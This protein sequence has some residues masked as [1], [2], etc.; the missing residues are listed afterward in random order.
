M[1]GLV[2]AVGFWLFGYG[3]WCFRCFAGLFSVV[4]RLGFQ[5]SGLVVAGVLVWLLV[6]CG[7]GLGWCCC[8]LLWF[9]WRGVVLV[10]GVRLVGMVLVVAKCCGFLLFARSVLLIVL[11]IALF[12][13][14]LCFGLELVVVLFECWCGLPVVGCCL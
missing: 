12:D 10:A 14:I 8:L 11:F 6:V 4:V 7:R 2:G 13:F 5:G 1:L 3:L 9:G